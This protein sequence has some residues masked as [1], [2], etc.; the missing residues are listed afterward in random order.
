MD[1]VDE[2]DWYCLMNMKIESEFLMRAISKYICLAKEM[3]EH[4]RRNHEKFK[5]GVPG[6]GIF[7]ARV[8]ASKIKL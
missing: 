8:T 5:G 1:G 2:I 3:V 6:K 4:H 7:Y